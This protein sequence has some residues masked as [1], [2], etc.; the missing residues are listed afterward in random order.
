MMTLAESLSDRV[1]KLEEKLRMLSRL[2]KNM[3]EE[4]SKLVGKIDASK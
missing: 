1:N 2:L 3:E 4:I